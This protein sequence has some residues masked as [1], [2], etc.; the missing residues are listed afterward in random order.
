MGLYSHTTRADGIVLTGGGSSSDIFNTDHQNHVTHTEPSSIDSWED[1]QAHMDRETDPFPSGVL[2]VPS[3]M[4]DE[5][6][7]L[8]YALSTIKAY[9]SSGTRPAHWYTAVTSFSNFVSFPPTACR[10]EQAT[11]QSIVS[12]ANIILLWDTTIYDTVGT[13]AGMTGLKAPASGTYIV[14]ACVGFGDGVTQGPIGD[15]RLTL[16]RDATAIG[17]DQIDSD[18]IAM[19]KSISVETVAHFAAG[20]LL[21]ARVFQ[22]NGTTK[23]P[24]SES[25]AR[26]AIWMAM[27]AR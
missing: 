17:T 12:G 11:A 9:M 20:A 24:V 5:L 21:K 26:P 22:T 15:F 7:R 16:L 3:S 19:P 14:G 4:A 18:S 2:S 1:T 8:R 25:D 13:M 27:V 23:T 10:M 6:E